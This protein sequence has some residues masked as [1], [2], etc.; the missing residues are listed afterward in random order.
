[1]H[2]LFFLTA[3]LLAVSLSALPFAGQS[4]AGAAFAQAQ[5]GPQTDL[6]AAQP[7]KEAPADAAPVLYRVTGVVMVVWIG[8]AVYL[9]TIDRR[10]SRLEKDLRGRK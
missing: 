4:H 2:K 9:F 8:L 7:E 3:A 10:L 5:A 1:M 6:N